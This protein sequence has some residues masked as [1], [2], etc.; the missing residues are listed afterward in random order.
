MIDCFPFAGYPVAVF[1]L[2]EEGRAAA[3][4]LHLSEA[5]ISAWDLGAARCRR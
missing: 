3:R 1:G 5:E 2:G 4:A